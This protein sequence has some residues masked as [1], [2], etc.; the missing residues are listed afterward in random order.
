M[1][2][3]SWKIILSLSSWQKSAME[4]AGSS[5]MITDLLTNQLVAF[6]NTLIFIVEF[7]KNSY[8]I[9][10]PQNRNWWRALV[11]TAMAPYLL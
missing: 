10:V 1:Y 3:H 2:D 9:H 11:N 6:Q 5:R 4:A 8:H 7:V